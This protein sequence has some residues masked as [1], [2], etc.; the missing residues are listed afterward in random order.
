MDKLFENWRNFRKETLNE[1]HPGAPIRLPSEDERPLDEEGPA[2][3][4]EIL[5]E[6][7]PELLT[8][9]IGA[10]A[11]YIA[12]KLDKPMITALQALRVARNPGTIQLMAKT[13]KGPI[14]MALGRATGVGIAI[15]IARDAYRFFLAENNIDNIREFHDM[16]AGLLVLPTHKEQPCWKNTEVPGFP[17]CRD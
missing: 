10:H 8:G 1:I 12:A 7:S 13:L 3:F 4:E 5:K 9:L 17:K 15:Q 2:F 11:G 16:V 6:L 14:A